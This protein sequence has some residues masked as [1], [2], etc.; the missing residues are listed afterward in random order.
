MP[1]NCMNELCKT[2]PCVECYLKELESKWSISF[3]KK[4]E[5]QMKS[6]E[7]TEIVSVSDRSA[8][9]T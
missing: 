6:K 9:K 3:K 8:K 5:E 7:D 4:E 1:S 2:K